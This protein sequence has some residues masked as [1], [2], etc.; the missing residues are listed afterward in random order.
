MPGARAVCQ[1][2]SA[3]CGQERLDDAL[4]VVSRGL[5]VV[6]FLCALQ[7]APGPAGELANRR[8]RT[9]EQGTDV[10][11]RVAE[12]IMKDERHPFGRGKGVHDDV[13]RSADL[14]RYQRVVGRVDR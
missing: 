4:V 8:A 13:H 5:D 1:F 12:H 9:P 11:E 10:A 2:A 3:R 6:W 14:F 7:F